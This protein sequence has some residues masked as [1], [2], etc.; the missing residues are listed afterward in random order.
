MTRFSQ[1]E[2]DESNKEPQNQNG[3][4]VRDTAYFYREAI[5]SRLAGDFELALRNYSR[6]LEKNN[7]VFEG[8]QGQSLMLIE[9]GE[10]KEA[11]VWINKALEL[12]P[13]QGDLY[14]ARAVAYH[15]DLIKDKAIES[16]DL[17]VGM[18]N[19][20]AYV[21]LARAEIMYGRKSS[22]AE[23]CLS[24]AISMA[25][26]EA[27]II[28]LECARLMRKHGKYSAAIEYL[29]DVVKIFSKSALAWYELGCCQSAL[30]LSSAKSA[31]EQSVALSPQWNAPR[32][33]L[34]KCK[35]GFF[36]RIF[37]G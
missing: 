22:I 11:I 9:L 33:E 27:G 35:P 7:M 5:R 31:L 6:M 30:G 8:W 17:S 24:K 13:Q 28:K 36:R 3:L 32:R 25:G 1:L 26:K 21:W 14:A 20:S 10:Y 18:E 2:F 12:F 23:N 29:N 15:R 4:P 34:S 16:S 19:Q 37:G